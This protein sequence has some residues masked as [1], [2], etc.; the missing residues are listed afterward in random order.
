MPCPSPIIFTTTLNVPSPLS[1][2]VALPWAAVPFAGFRATLGFAK[3]GEVPAS[4]VVTGVIVAGGM[5]FPAGGEAGLSVVAAG[6]DSE[7]AGVPLAIA[8]PAARLLEAV[9][10]VE[11]V[12]TGAVVTVVSTT[13]EVEEVTTGGRIPG[14]FLFAKITEPTARKTEINS[15]P[16]P[17]RIN[18]KGTRC[19]VFG[20][21][22]LT[23]GRRW[24]LVSSGSSG[25][26]LGFRVLLLSGSWLT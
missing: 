18:F 26:K 21:L 10:V 4:R 17:P 9:P 23:A 15:N 22:G 16:I 20:F 5:V 1:V 24:L 7:R 14:R 8:V 25:G 2:K 19:F 11:A 6:T 12:V 3:A 13:G